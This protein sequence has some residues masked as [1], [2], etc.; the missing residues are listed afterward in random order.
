MSDVISNIFTCNVTS[1][2]RDELL[3]HPFVTGTT[4]S[5]RVAIHYRGCLKGGGKNADLGRLDV[6]LPRLEQSCLTAEYRA[7]KLIRMSMKWAV[8]LLSKH[9]KL[10]VIHYT[11][12]PRGTLL[13]RLGLQT[14]YFRDAETFG[15]RAKELCDQM[16]QDLDETELVQNTDPELYG[17]V[18]RIRYEDLALDPVK[19]A[20]QIYDFLDL[21]FPKGI[22]DWLLKYTKETDPK[23][24]AT[25]VHRNASHV[26]SKWRQGLDPAYQ[27]L[28]AEHCNEVLY[29]LGYDTDL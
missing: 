7:V 9:R 16:R 6:C 17:R 19:T 24:L 28:A 10:K 5:R 14:N 1:L 13:S 26:A 11:R 22:R 29:K 15:Q 23:G 27:A 21:E 25:S 4:I 2:P 8:P 12:D 20:T 18:L 3:R